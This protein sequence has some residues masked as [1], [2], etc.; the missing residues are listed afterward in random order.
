MTQLNGLDA[1]DSQWNLLVDPLP[2]QSPTGSDIKHT[3]EYDALKEARREDDSTLPTGVWQKEP[4]RVNWSEVE[5][6]ASRL[7]GTR[8]KD[9]MIAAWLGEAWIHRYHQ[10]GLERALTFIKELCQRY[11]VRLHPSQT[12]Q[13]INWLA[14]P[15]AWIVQQYAQLLL[16]Q[17]PIVGD[18]VPGFEK[19][20]QVEWTS[21]NNQLLCKGDDSRAKAKVEA[22]RAAQQKFHDAV[23]KGSRERLVALSQRLTSCVLTAEE[24]Q[25]WI[26]NN[27]VEEAP[28]VGPLKEVLSQ[29]LTAL[30][31]LIAMHPTP[32][33]TSFEVHEPQEL[34]QLDDLLQP[35]QTDCLQPNAPQSRSHA[36]QQLQVI[37]NYL[38]TTEPHSPVPYLINRAIA[39]GNM[40]FNELMAQLLDADIETRKI[41]TLLGV[42]TTKG[43][44]GTGS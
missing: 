4:K 35:P 44:R 9:L 18:A 12:E 15:L 19:L 21:L 3:L 40:P 2:G 25:D 41:W 6:Q 34:S 5:K 10:Y 7:L 11:A 29:Q 30:Q 17:V 36:Y 33:I 23:R 16:L 26:D 28:S 31:E 27:I 38:A 14:P 1:I 43:D 39:W 42:F 24:L 37:S 22:A 13:D 32:P 8:T 20:T